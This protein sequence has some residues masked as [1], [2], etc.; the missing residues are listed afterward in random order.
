MNIQYFVLKN[1]PEQPVTEELIEK[2]ENSL[3]QLHA[4]S[5]LFFDYLCSEQ[6]DDSVKQFFWIE[7]KS[8]EAIIK[9]VDDAS[10]PVVYLI[11]KA[12]YK[13][14]IE[15]IASCLN[16]YI[17][18]Y[19]LEQLKHKA[20]KEMDINPASLLLLALGVSVE[21]DPVSSQIFSDALKSRNSATRYAAAEAVGLLQWSELITE[22]R[23]VAASDTNADVREIASISLEA[24]ESFPK[25]AIDIDTK[26]RN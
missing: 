15:L 2:I 5:G 13:Q 14:D 25:V 3:T 26:G 18:I 20:I 17:S 19:S 22:L 6:L 16:Q 4:K 7:I 24:C 1:L 21:F 9:L 12:K 10:I 8:E 11:A 23:H